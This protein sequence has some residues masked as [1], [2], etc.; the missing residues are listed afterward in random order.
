MNAELYATTVAPRSSR[1]AGR[2]KLGLIVLACALP[3]VAAWASYRFFPPE[4]GK[5][6][7]QLLE[8]RPLPG[9]EAP[10]WPRG[11]W[12][13]A[14]V[15]APGPCDA[16]CERRLFTQ[17][18]IQVAQGEASERLVR[19]RLVAGA[20]AQGEAPSRAEVPVRAAPHLASRVGAGLYLIDP[21]GNTV[22]FY[23][24]AAEPGRVIREV[25]KI[26]KTNNGLG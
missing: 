10:D 1:R 21:L 13:L 7:G 15:E 16:R 3:A 11:K 23:P 20:V 12:V 4:G 18:Q 9:S 22:M 17:R 24:D 14:T 25:G 6:Y 26:L 2:I 19:L 8:V 5:S